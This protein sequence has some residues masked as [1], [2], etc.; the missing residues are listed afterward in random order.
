MLPPSVGRV[1]KEVAARAKLREWTTMF[2]N[3]TYSRRLHLEK[4]K[5]FWT[6]SKRPLVIGYSVGR[7]GAL[8]ISSVFSSALHERSKYR[9]DFCEA[10]IR[11]TSVSIARGSMIHRDKC[12]REGSGAEILLGKRSPSRSAVFDFFLLNVP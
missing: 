12:V 10:S 6:V 9:S 11:R 7:K 3:S 1:S 4:S 8:P 5:G 2:L